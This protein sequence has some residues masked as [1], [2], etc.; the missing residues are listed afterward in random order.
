MTGSKTLRNAYLLT[1][2]RNLWTAVDRSGW[3]GS[4]ACLITGPIMYGLLLL[5]S[6]EEFGVRDALSFSYLIA[7]TLVAARRICDMSGT[8]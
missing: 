8:F 1:P 6:Q 2:Q 5:E 3:P 7:Q 4:L